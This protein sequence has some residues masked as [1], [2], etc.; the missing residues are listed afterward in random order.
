MYIIYN[1]YYTNIINNITI[2][3]FK[4]I[5]DYYKISVLINVNY[6][7]EIITFIMY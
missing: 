6:I 4:W 2:Y 3:I 5:R 7:F 1:I